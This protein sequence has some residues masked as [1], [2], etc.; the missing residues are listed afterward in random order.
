M[1]LYIANLTKQNIDFAYRVPEEKGARLQN[2]KVGSQIKITG[3]GGLNTKQ[4]DAIINQNRKYGL[5][6]VEEIDKTK[7]F[8]GMCFSVDSPVSIAK[9][10]RA[11]SHNTKVLVERGQEMRQQAAVAEARRIEDHLTE[12]SSPASLRNYEM[13]VVEENHSG[14][15]GLD[16]VAEGTRVNRTTDEGGRPS[17][18]RGGGRGSRR[19]K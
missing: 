12:E 19:G 1:D 2:I 5:I 11:I 3:P 7:P 9:I 13:S 14:A 15:S 4:V 10:E 8:A 17:P 16:P 6:G 18:Q